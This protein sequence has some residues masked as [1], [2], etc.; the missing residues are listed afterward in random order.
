MIS[1]TLTKGCKHV[2]GGDTR[3]LTHRKHSSTSETALMISRTPPQ[4]NLK[5]IGEDSHWQTGIPMQWILH[6]EEYEPDSQEQ[7]ASNQEEANTCSHKCHNKDGMEIPHQG[8]QEKSSVTV[9]TN[10]DI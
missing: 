4:G 8:G 10:Q 3:C 5:E 1:S 9:V 7:K 2:S 6:W